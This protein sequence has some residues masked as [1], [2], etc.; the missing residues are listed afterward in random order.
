MLSG[1]SE[2][3]LCNRFRSTCAGNCSNV[4]GMDCC[5][6]RSALAGIG[7]KSANK[8]TQHAGVQAHSQTQRTL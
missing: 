2:G 1:E 3:E 6:V 4:L 7:P 5:T 8:S